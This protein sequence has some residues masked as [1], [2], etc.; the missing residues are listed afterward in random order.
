[1]CNIMVIYFRI[2]QKVQRNKRHSRS[3]QA[4]PSRSEQADKSIIGE[5][6]VE[7]IR[8]GSS[9]S[10]QIDLRGMIRLEN[11]R[12]KASGEKR[13]RSERSENITDRE[14]SRAK[15]RKEKRSEN[16]R[17]DSEKSSV[18]Q[19]GASSVVQNYTQRG[20]YTI[21]E[22]RKTKAAKYTGKWKIMR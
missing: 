3:E 21:R 14:K 5:I 9:R 18:E 13:V 2:N 11:S 8:Y 7:Q 22:G 12:V 16:I 4:D 19:I 20:E 10:G 17:V 6:R 15:K 1:M